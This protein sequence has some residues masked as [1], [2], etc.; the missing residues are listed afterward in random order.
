MGIFERKKGN[1]IGRGASA[2]PRESTNKT[3]GQWNPQT[4][5]VNLSK[6][7]VFTGQQAYETVG[8]FGEVGAAKSTGSA[9][10]FLLAYLAAGMG[11]LYNCV[12]PEDRALLEQYAKMTGREKSLIIVS[13]ENPWRC[14]LLKYALKRPGAVGSRVEQ[15]VSLLLTIVEAAERG[16]KGGGSKDKFWDRSLKQILRNA[17]E[18]CIAADGDMSMRTLHAIISSAPTSHAQVQDPA[19]QEK[20][21][22][23]RHIC[24][25]DEK[26]LPERQRK[27]FQLAAEYFLRDYPG[28]PEETRGSVLAT[29]GVMAD[30]LLRGHMADL[31]D[32]GMNFVPEMSFEGGIIVPDMPLKVYGQAG[33]I[34]QAAFT[35]L[36]QTAAEQRDMSGNPRGVFWFMDEAHELVNGHTSRFLAT[37]RSR[38]VA[39]IL[40]TQNLANYAAAFGSDGRQ[41][42]DDIVSNISTKIFHANGHVET[43]EWASKT[44]SD[45]VQTR[46]NF[47]G[48]GQQTGRGGGGGSESVGHKVLPAE[49]TMMKK[50][51][52][53]NDFVTEAIIYRTGAAYIANDGQPFLRTAF[54]Q[55]IP[56]VTD[57]MVRP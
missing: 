14:N 41:K 31:F 12:K 50:G 56:G 27:D 53:Q 6:T 33:L 2:P 52:P 39:P 40:I 44:I 7:D 15:L 13:P 16:E 55:I 47:H 28:M 36:W 17:I 5:L 35:Y 49:F 43:N 18:I 22:C 20:S 29:Y 19:W 51:G 48:G 24:I 3:T 38:R 23:Y 54:P 30:V 4:P 45:E 37:A 21:E 10:H 1:V 25:G 34:V 11:G 8:I 26:E 57:K 42:A 9:A 32:G 46:Y